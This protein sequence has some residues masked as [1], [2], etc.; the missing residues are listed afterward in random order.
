MPDS[1]NVAVVRRFY[2]NLSSPEILTQ[3]L[4]PTIRWEIVPGFPYGG[5][6]I[7]VETV[8]RDFFGRVLSD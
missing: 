4:A 1:A 7:G 6:Y 3:V 8:F 5:D 2:D